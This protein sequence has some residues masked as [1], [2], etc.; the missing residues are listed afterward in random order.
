MANLTRRNPFLEPFED[1]DRMFS[2]F[3]PALRGRGRDERE[4]SF[5]PAIDMYEEENNV[6]VETQLPGVDSKDVDLSVEDNVLTLKGK[7]EKKNE[8][9][10]KDYY[11]KEIMKGSFY[12]SIPLPASV[13][14]EEAKAVAEDGVLKVTIPKAEEK[15]SSKIEI[16]DRSKK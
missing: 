5:M 1:M 7:S 12:R 9:D 4:F 3:L 13:K 11:K 6:I 15:K 2:D 14:G 16:E 8:V 10:E